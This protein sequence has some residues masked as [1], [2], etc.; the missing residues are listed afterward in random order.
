MIGHP[1]PLVRLG[2]RA[3]LAAEQQCLVVGDAGDGPRM[4]GLAGCLQPHVLLVDAELL[5][6]RASE[7]VERIHQ[8]APRTRLVILGRCGDVTEIAALAEQG[9]AAF[10]PKH[11]GAFAVVEA[12]RQAAAGRLGMR[13]WLDAYDA[14]TPRERDVLHLSVAGFRVRAIAERLCVS[15]RT[16]AKHRENLTAKLGLRGQTERI[17]YALRRGLCSLGGQLPPLSTPVNTLASRAV[18]A[19]CNEEAGKRAA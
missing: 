16:V 3:V 15:W 13:M 14:L 9:T 11:A 8:R 4:V 12:V 17:H 5:D 1:D 19:S 7:L 18:S 2:M 10:L 6:G